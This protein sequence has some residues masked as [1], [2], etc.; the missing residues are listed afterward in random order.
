MAL[1]RPENLWEQIATDI[2]GRIAGGEYAPGTRLP[3]EA[4]MIG[5]YG[6]SRPVV[7]QAIAALRA[8]GIVT[9]QHGKGAWVREQSAP[10]GVLERRII[11]TGSGAK[12]RYAEPEA[13][14]EAEEPT[15]YRTVT[16]AETGPMLGL[17]EGEA[18]FAADRLLTHEETGARVMHRVVLPFTTA[19]GTSLEQDPH[20][21]PAE[22]YT[23][24]AA[25]GH[26]LIWQ[27][28]TAARMP[29]PDEAAT[30]GLGEGVPL[31]VIRRITSGA[32]R[33]LLFEETR[34]GADAF[35]AE[36]RVTADTARRSPQAV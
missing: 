21:A 22:I 20:Q 18:C 12:A 13:Y 19:D 2:R 35:R 26:A 29:T 11:R 5:A 17:G 27:E 7:R 1:M 28:Q 36:H 25:A 10:T 30:L 6:V 32:D 4:Q 14:A 15:R 23:A 34:A 9:V 8:E 16:D 24:L 33:P 3:S 31:L